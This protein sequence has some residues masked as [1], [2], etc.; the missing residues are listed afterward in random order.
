MANGESGDGK[1][2][3][4]RKLYDQSFWLY[5]AYTPFVTVQVW[6]VSLFLGVLLS[7]LLWDLAWFS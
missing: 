5:T 6:G 4:L 7:I 1:G 2:K 3:A